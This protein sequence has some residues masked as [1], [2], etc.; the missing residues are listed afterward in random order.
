MYIFVLAILDGFHLHFTVRPLMTQTAY[1][2]PH[3]WVCECKTVYF[4]P[5]SLSVCLHTS[6]NW[7]CETSR[8]HFKQGSIHSRLLWPYSSVPR[9]I[10]L[11]KSSVTYS[12]SNKQCLVKRDTD[13]KLD[14]FCSL[15]V[16][17]YGR[18]LCPQSHCSL[19]HFLTHC[20]T[21]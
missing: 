16:L 21:T 2:W 6:L 12:W 19:N 11:S 9:H 10:C 20:A 17:V 1:L 4:F 15:D 14:F 13:G 5:Y 3:F 8:C 18:S 7:F